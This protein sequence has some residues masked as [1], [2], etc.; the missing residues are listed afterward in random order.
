MT[1]KMAVIGFSYLL[2]LFIASY[3]SFSLSVK[4]GLIIIPV[5]ILFAVILRK[6]MILAWFVALTTIGCSFLWYGYYGLN[7]YNKIISLNEQTVYIEAKVIDYKV[8]SNNNTVCLCKSENLDKNFEFNLYTY[9]L[10]LD[11]DSEFKADIN[12]S[13]YQN[14]QYFES[15]EYYKANDIFLYGNLEKVYEVTNNKTFNYYVKKYSDYV[16]AKISRLLPNDSGAIVNAMFT[17][18]KTYYSGILR[19]KMYRTGIGHILAISGFH[20]TVIAGMLMFVL[21]PA[22]KYISIPILIAF[23]VIF[24]IFTGNSISSIRACIMITVFYLSQLANRKAD[25]LNSLGL[26]GFLLTISS[27]FAVK[28]ASLLLSLIGT[29]GV[30]VMGT[31]INKKLDDKRKIKTRI[32]KFTLLR[33]ALII[34]LSAGI[35]TAPI[36][37]MVFD[38]ISIIGPFLLIVV[39]PICSLVLYLSL[40]YGVLGC[41]PIF[42]FIIKFAGAIVNLMLIII[43]FVDKFDFIYIHINKDYIQIWAFVTGFVLVFLFLITKNNKLLIKVSAISICVL[44]TFSVCY[45]IFDDTK[46]SIVALSDSKTGAVV[47][48]RDKSA[49]IIVTGTDGSTAD[50]I[51]DFLQ[52]NNITIINSIIFNELEPAYYPHYVNLYKNYQI[53]NIVASDEDLSL[54]E[55]TFLFDKSNKISLE[56]VEKISKECY[57]IEVTEDGYV[58]RSDDF[59]MLVTDYDEI[60]D[61]Y[62]IVVISQKEF[63]LP[64]FDSIYLNMRAGEYDDKIINVYRTPTFILSVNY[65]DEIT[66]RSYGYAFYGRANYN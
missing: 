24:C 6:R 53:D 40:I 42:N 63:T 57:N 4:L 52:Q 16:S 49:D 21:K 27:P 44:L 55:S 13:K 66:E 46:F 1:R 26:A 39:T 43:D 14:N 29:F 18:D 17:G 23:C 64:E 33:R 20:F 10:I 60:Y 47:I 25:S 8:L 45:K 2:G 11:Y 32:T 5:G 62:D 50:N 48:Y 28:D 30:A 19:D 65:N 7:T 35:C 38:G 56:K 54:L 51:T 31:Y 22:K 61:E 15:A 58:V 3:F 36:S 34:S 9:D 12:F 59:S 37:I 41:L